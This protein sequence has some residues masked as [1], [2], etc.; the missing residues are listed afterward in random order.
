MIYDQ[1]DGAGYVPQT[2]MSPWTWVGAGLGEPA[3]RQSLRLWYPAAG[4][5]AWHCF[6]RQHHLSFLQQPG[7]VEKPLRIFLQKLASQSV[8]GALAATGYITV[9]EAY[10]EPIKLLAA[11]EIRSHCESNRLADGFVLWRFVADQ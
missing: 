11:K 5:A 7:P 4:T 9:I 10:L 8:R 2:T 6:S 1:G 3:A